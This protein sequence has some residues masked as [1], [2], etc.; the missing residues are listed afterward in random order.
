VLSRQVDGDIERT[1]LPISIDNSIAVMQTVKACKLSVFERNPGLKGLILALSTSFD[2]KTAD[3][4]YCSDNT[5]VFTILLKTSFILLFW[6]N[7]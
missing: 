1:I 2:R 7:Y 4:C 3:L 6:E 5:F